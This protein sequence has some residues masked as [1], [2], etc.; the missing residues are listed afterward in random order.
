MTAVQKNSLFLHMGPGFHAQIEG[1]LFS[2]AHPD[3]IFWSQPKVSSFALLRS[4]VEAFVS[5]LPSEK[6]DLIAH[7]F[8]AQLVL[9]LM[10]K[11]PQKIGRITLLNSAVDPFECFLNLGLQLRIVTPA[12]LRD[13]R[14][15]DVAKK[16][17][18]I[19]KVATMP[20]FDDHY[21][22]SGQKKKDFAEIFARFP[23]LDVGVFAEIFSDYL[24]S[25]IQF[26]DSIKPW[27]KSVEIYTS[28]NDNLLDFEKDVFPWKQFF[29]KA[30]WVMLKNSGHYALFEDKALSAT[31]FQR[32]RKLDGF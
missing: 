5:S 7:S 2:T 25:R 18:Y 15:G 31:V 14:A 28:E 6:I 17:E 8:G 10:Q 1:E 30:R 27:D 4:E 29:P 32:H 20:G 12:Q 21:W 22:Y 13:I 16:M 3:V 19:F 26:L 11:L 9:G 24:R 23:Q